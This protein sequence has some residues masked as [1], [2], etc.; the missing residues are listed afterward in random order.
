MKYYKLPSHTPSNFY[1]VGECISQASS[2]ID[3]VSKILKPLIKGKERI[4]IYCTGSSGAILSGLLFNKIKRNKLI[5][6]RHIKKEG[7]NSHATNNFYFAKDKVNIILDDFVATGET[8]QRII[9]TIENYNGNKIM[10]D[11]CI[12]SNTNNNPNSKFPSKFKN[13]ISKYH[14]ND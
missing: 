6:I 10:F 13:I 12:T 3:E 9:K 2:F 1:P 4:D 11:Y 14:P 7:E 8:F 5:E